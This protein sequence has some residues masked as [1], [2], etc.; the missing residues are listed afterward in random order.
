MSIH[1][2]AARGLTYR[3]IVRQIFKDAHPNRF[4]SG[5]TSLPV[6]KRF[7]IDEH[8]SGMLC[9]CSWRS[10]STHRY[11]R[12]PTFSFDAKRCTGLW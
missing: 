5:K 8:W 3:V 11:R 12:C 7:G 6:D 10:L 1:I 4:M 2:H 9:R